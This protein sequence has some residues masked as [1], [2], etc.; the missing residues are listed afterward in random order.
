MVI[1]IL[2]ALVMLAVGV[3]VLRIAGQL[4]GPVALGVAPAVGLATVVV[5]ATW[6]ALLGAPPVL[7]TALIVC[8][9]LC[10]TVVAARE[11][12]TARLVLAHGGPILAA[13][14]LLAV[15]LLV[16]IV[17]L[18]VAFTDV[19]VPLSSHDGGYHVEVVQAFRTGSRL[20]AVG[21]YPPGF[22]V[23]VAAFLQ[24]L[25]WVDSALGTFGA[26]LGL[27]LL[28]PMVTFGLGCA[29][30]RKP[31]VAATGALLIALTFQFPYYANFWAGWPLTSALIMVLGLWAVAIEY[32]QRPAISWVLVASVLAAGVL[33]T[34]GTEVYTASVGLVVI[35]VAH[36]RT[37]RWKPIWRH[38]P[39]A[40]GIA[41]VLTLPYLPTLFAW[42]HGGGAVQ[43]ASATP[44]DPSAAVS[45]GAPPTND[46]LFFWIYALSTGIVIDTPVRALLLLGG[47]W[48][49]FRHRSGRLLVA[50]A[51]TFFVLDLL[52]LYTP[53]S[54]VH[55][56]FALT[57]PWGQ[58]YRLDTMVA[59]TVALLQAAGALVVVE[60]AMRR[61]AR[62]RRWLAAIGGLVVVGSLCGMIGLFF[63]LASS[64]NTYSPD[65]VAAMAWLREHAQPGQVIANDGS[66]DAGIWAPYKAGVTI[67]KPRASSWAPSDSV[68]AILDNITR[69]DTVPEARAAACALGVEYV[70][71]GASGTAWEPRH[72]PSS[73]A[74]RQSQA[75][76]EVFA[77]GDA[78]VFRVRTA[79]SH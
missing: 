23:A 28:A 27:S 5:V 68:A 48:W 19:S 18:G 71:H 65:D 64:Y 55:Q 45:L 10:G 13:F 77:S 14:G 15:A 1:G 12:S 50:V 75:L 37:A 62:V 39:I 21:W 2:F 17:A 41:L 24:L 8:L 35:A 61:A 72:F 44:A 38:L 3:A 67:L 53:V 36:A 57:Y 74:L 56:I 42:A 9:A 78:V 66:T 51:L 70:Y 47:I 22:H 34:H 43:A 33:L 54:V 20:Q 30:W 25:P 79:C 29:V 63:A 4:K 6:Q 11:L 52:F 40:L 59:V 76:E 58:S 32:I 26:S 69:L 46:V 49:A 7:A 60:W 73:E 31:L 16:P